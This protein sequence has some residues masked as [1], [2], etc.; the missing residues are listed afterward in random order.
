MPWPVIEARGLV[1]RLRRGAPPALDHVSFN[2]E[3]GEIF[4]LLGADG[5][6]KTTILHVLAGLR[7]PTAGFARIAG[8]DVMAD[9]RHLR[10]V[11]GYLA[12][13]PPVPRNRT[14][15]GY[16][17]D[18]A[19]IEGMSR[20]DRRARRDALFEALGLNDVAGERV[21][22]CTTFAQRRLFLGMAIL[23]NPQ[24]LLLD[25]P[26]GGLI[27]ADRDA[28][29]DLVREVS[30]GKT[31]VLATSTLA[32]A[33]PVCTRIMTLAEGRAS[34]V[35]DAAVILRAV[36]EAHHAR[37]FVDPGVPFA[38]AGPVLRSVPGVL[39]VQ[40]TPPVVT[41]FVDPG[42]FEVDELRRVLAE[43]EMEPRSV[44]ETEIV[45]GDIIRTLMRREAA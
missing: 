23:S 39:D 1:Q 13:S 21:I 10:D 25:E 22:D 43:R 7:P 33:Q 2:V 19:R 38:T 40:E 4:G 30:V 37:V 17:D 3:R 29:L 42:V 34:Q 20:Q 11:V 24:V 36:G 41:L 5:A 44:K 6:G 16:L 32:N 12:Q 28:F 9:R 27:P 31:T 45:L 26:M 14:V 8:H 35:Y 18:W 15:A